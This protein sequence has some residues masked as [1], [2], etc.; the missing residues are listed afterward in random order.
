LQQEADVI[1]TPRRLAPGDLL[2]MA[3]AVPFVCPYSTA[4]TAP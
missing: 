3:T 2:T 1:R 4:R